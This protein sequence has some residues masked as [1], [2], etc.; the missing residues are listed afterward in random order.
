[1]GWEPDAPA[2][3][4]PGEAAGTAPGQNIEIR[5]PEVMDFGKV[6]LFG[7]V[8]KRLAWLTQR[9]EILSQNIANADTPK[10]RAKD[11]EPFKFEAMVRRET[12]AQMNV[13]RTDAGHLEGVRHR[14]TDFREEVERRPWET[15][16]AGNAVI[17]EEQMAKVNETQMAHK[18]TTKLY[19]KHLGMIAIALGKR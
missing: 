17:L 4:A 1:M 13:A 9:Q 7:A 12:G 15:A 6:A 8:K 14:V 10:Y 2:A 16:P 5:E 3:E 18:L 11:I 19:Q